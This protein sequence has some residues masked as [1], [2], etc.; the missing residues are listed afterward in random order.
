MRLKGLFQGYRY[1]RIASCLSDLLQSW[2]N[3][4]LHAISD[5]LSGIELSLVDYMMNNRRGSGL[6]IMQ[7]T[8]YRYIF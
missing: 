2:S 6:R 7:F 5:S 8:N 4:M 3:V 1:K